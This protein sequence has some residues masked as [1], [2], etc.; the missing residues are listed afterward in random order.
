M[1]LTNYKGLSKPEGRGNLRGVLEFFGSYKEG[2][3]LI[4]ILIA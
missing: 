2:V 1:M 3:G 4:D